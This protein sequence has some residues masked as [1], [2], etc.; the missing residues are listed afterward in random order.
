MIEYKTHQ[1]VGDRLVW[2]QIKW[3]GEVSKI[4]ID[5]NLEVINNLRKIPVVI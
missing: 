4:L 3:T 1:K 2:N 5:R